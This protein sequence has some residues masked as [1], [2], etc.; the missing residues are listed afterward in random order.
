MHQ[1]DFETGM[2]AAKHAFAHLHRGVRLQQEYQQS[3][4]TNEKKGKRR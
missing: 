3:D 2:E 1:H 4:F